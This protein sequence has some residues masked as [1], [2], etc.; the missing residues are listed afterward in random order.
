[1]KYCIMKFISLLLLKILSIYDGRQY[2]TNSTGCAQIS[3]G[4]NHIQN[5]KYHD[6]HCNQHK[7]SI[8]ENGV[9]FQISDFLKTLQ[10]VCTDMVIKETDSI[11]HLEMTDEFYLMTYT[12]QTIKFGCYN[13]DIAPNSPPKC[14]FG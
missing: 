1:M 7:D 8:N 9:P 12:P 5:C 2:L 6:N 3:R 11:L 4:G 13:R 14:K 10:A